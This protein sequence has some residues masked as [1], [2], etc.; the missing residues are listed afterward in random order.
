MLTPQF[1][2]L[3]IFP[4]LK[5]IK[6]GTKCQNAQTTSI[7]SKLV[8]AKSSWEKR[9]IMFCFLAIH[10]PAL[11]QIILSSGKIVL[12]RILKKYIQQNSMYYSA[13]FQFSCV[14]HVSVSRNR[15]TLCETPLFRIEVTNMTHCWRRAVIFGKRAL[16]LIAIQVLRKSCPCCNV[17]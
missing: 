1:F 3:K 17:T 10:A 15:H 6:K 16:F 5:D 13:E 8:K 14:W 7:F 4:R 2:N 11:S 9:Q 12:G